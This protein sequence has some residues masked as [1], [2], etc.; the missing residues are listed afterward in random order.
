MRRFPIALV[1][2][3]GFWSIS[4]TEPNR[5]TRRWWS[6]VRVFASD[7]MEGRDTGSTGYRKAAEY[8]AATFAR[9]GLQPAGVAGYYQPVPLHAV[10]FAAERS[11]VELVRTD[12]QTESLRWQREI[13]LPP[14]I[15]TRKR[16]MRRSVQ[17]LG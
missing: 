7:D 17:W 14:R 1:V 16:S 6:H 8:V 10:R 12:G 11:R 9:A 3:L 5:A 2:V 15:G 13:T 4:A